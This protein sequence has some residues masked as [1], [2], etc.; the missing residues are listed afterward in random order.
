[1]RIS[2]WSSDVCSSDLQVG[3]ARA[4]AKDNAELIQVVARRAGVHHFYRATGQAEGHGPQRARLGPV[5]KLV[6]AGGYKTFFH[7]AVDS[8]N[9]PLDLDCMSDCACRT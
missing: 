7:N 6:C 2:D 1:M 9:L 4:G 5:Q 8:H 3:L